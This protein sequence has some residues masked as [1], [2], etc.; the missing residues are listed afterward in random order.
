MKLKSE[1]LAKLIDR[2]LCMYPYESVSYRKKPISIENLC[3]INDRLG[4]KKLE[5]CFYTKLNNGIVFETLSSYGHG[6]NNNAEEIVVVNGTFKGNNFY[7]DSAIKIYSRYF[8]EK[9]SA[10]ITAIEPQIDTEIE[11]GKTELIKLLMT[12]FETLGYKQQE[13]NKVITK[14]I[15]ASELF[16]KFMLRKGFWEDSYKSVER[17]HIQ[18]FANADNPNSIKIAKENGAEG[19]GLVR[20]E[21]MTGTSV[22]D[23]LELF[24]AAGEIPISIR[25]LLED[26]NGNKRANLLDYKPLLDNICEAAYDTLP[27]LTIIFPAEILKYDEMDESIPFCDELHSYRLANYR[28]NIGAIIESP[29]EEMYK[30]LDIC[31][32]SSLCFGTNDISAKL[33]GYARDGKEIALRKEASVLTPEVKKIL[34]SHILKVKEFNSTCM[35]GVCG[36][37]ASIPENVAMFQEL[38]IDYLSCVPKEIGLI[39]DRLLSTKLPLINQCNEQHSSVDEER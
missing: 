26:Q 5:D 23:F 33:Y 22:N 15:S 4:N 31:V 35:F 3:K 28:F 1:E 30:D 25:L 2:T 9:F 37:H 13:I 34:K 21:N 27:K 8:D 32:I 12:S 24:K 14:E 10:E 6:A 38:G 11:E 17:G 19:I 18:V 36:Y 7:F 29:L 39:R 16:K 20:I